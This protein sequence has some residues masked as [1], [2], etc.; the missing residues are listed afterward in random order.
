DLPAASR[1]HPAG[2]SGAFCRLSANEAPIGRLPHPS[3]E[4]NVVV[5]AARL[6][7]RSIGAGTLA[8]AAA[9]AIA[10][11]IVAHAAEA[12][13]ATAIAAAGI[14]AIAA[15]IEQGQV[16]VEALQHHFGGIFVLA[17]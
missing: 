8:A 14:V 9:I 13:I 4:R 3:S 7:G 16:R 15:A 5:H 2:L 12:G 11:A 10:I 6:E 17:G 1:R